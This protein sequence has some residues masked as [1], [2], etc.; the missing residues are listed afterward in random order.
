MTRRGSLV[1]YLTAWVCGCLFMSLGVWLLG[2][3][4]PTHWTPGF[5]G[6][7]GFLAFCFLGLLFGAFT[8]LLFAFLLRRLMRM[9]GAKHPWQW[10][11]AGAGLACLLVWGLGALRRV[12]E[13]APAPLEFALILLLGAPSAIHPRLV[14]VALPVGA[15]TAF[16]LHSV[17]RAF[18]P[19][20]D[21][22]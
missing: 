6:A 13:P 4:E 12:A 7:S 21:P 16:V 17:S 10:M 19:Q 18:E 22:T 1:Y 5:R 15:V 3:W 8:A 14:S 9:L 11:L 20:P 2:T